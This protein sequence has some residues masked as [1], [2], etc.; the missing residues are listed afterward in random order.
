MLRNRITPG[1]SELLVF[2]Y[3]VRHPAIWRNLKVTS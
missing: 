1:G 2:E 3:P